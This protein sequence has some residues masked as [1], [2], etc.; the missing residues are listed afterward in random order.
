MEVNILK[1]A[2]NNSN[3]ISDYEI[4]K[5]TIGKR[6]G[7]I[8]N[9]EYVF[10]DIKNI[11]EGVELPSDREKPLGTG[12]AILS[13]KDVVNEPFAVINADDFY[14]YDAF[15][16]A[17]DFLNSKSTDYAMIGYLIGNTLTENG[18]VKRGV[19][20]NCRWS[21]RINYRKFNY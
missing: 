3:I 11:P 12:H 9:V 14:G 10:Q 20:S 4:F 15:E 8:I 13:C 16:K 21:F 1:I 17:A 2:N 7:D 5:D 19:I 18:S 6:I